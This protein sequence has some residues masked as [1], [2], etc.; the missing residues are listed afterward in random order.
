MK[1]FFHRFRLWLFLLLMILAGTACWWFLSPYS[2]ITKQI[3]AGAFTPSGLFR[4]F[5]ADPTGSSLELAN[6]VIVLTGRVSAEGDGYIMLGQ[7]MAVVR[8]VFKK[9]IFNR[10]EQ[11][12]TGDSITLKGVCRGLNLT[13]VLV[14]HCILVDK[15]SR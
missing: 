4:E 11:V 6:K 15:T 3:P 9:A 10:S 12:V 14:T 8:C 5:T 2:N 7:D 1:K 13:E